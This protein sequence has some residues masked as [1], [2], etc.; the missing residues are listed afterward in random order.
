M[1]L[2][3]VSNIALDP[4]RWKGLP[5]IGGVPKGLSGKVVEELK[6]GGN[7]GGVGLT[8]GLSGA[9]G[10]VTGGVGLT[11][12]LSGVGGVGLTKGLSGTG[13]GVTGGNTGGN[14]GGVGTTTG[15][16]GGTLKTMGL[17]SPNFFKLYS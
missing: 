1:G 10:G 13:G 12:G 5:D 16:G 8:K 7:T 11:K 3:G 17:G 4:G 2:N 9:G 6:S 14:T 15:G